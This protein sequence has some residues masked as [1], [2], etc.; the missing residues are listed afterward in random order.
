MSAGK[1]KTLSRVYEINNFLLHNVKTIFRLR[2][3]GLSH[4]QDKHIYAYAVTLLKDH[5]H[6]LEEMAEVFYN[7]CKSVLN[8]SEILTTKGKAFK[9]ISDEFEIFYYLEAWRKSADKIAYIENG[10]VKT[11]LLH[12]MSCEQ[13]AFVFKK[14]NVDLF[15]ILNKSEILQRYDSHADK[16][17]ALAKCSYL[18]SAAPPKYK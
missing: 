11:E 8:C 12:R 5:V 9:I 17:V 1:Q 15:E 7:S 14:Y 13:A 4:S 10:I 2:K 18:L 3:I 6:T 16:Y